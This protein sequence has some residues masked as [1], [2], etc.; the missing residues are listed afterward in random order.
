MSLVKVELFK[1]PAFVP[2]ND[3]QHRSAIQAQMNAFMA[4]IAPQDILQLDLSYASDGKYSEEYTY[5]G[6]ITYFV[7]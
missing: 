2:G 7:P 3:A 5:I 6:H 1:S 4:T